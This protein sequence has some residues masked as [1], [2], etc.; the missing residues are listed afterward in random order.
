M[1]GRRIR[2]IALLITI[3]LVGGLAWSIHATIH[4]DELN[5][6]LIIAVK[7][8][9]AKTV[10]TLLGQG[11][12]PNSRDETPRQ[13]SLWYLLNK[14]WRRGTT[15]SFH[16]ALLIAMDCDDGSKVKLRE[17][18]VIIKAL[19]DSGADISAKDEDGSTPLIKACMVD[20]LDSVKLL[21]ARG[22]NVN[23]RDNSGS[24][25]LI[26]SAHFEPAVAESLL[27]KGA[28][29]DSQDM[30]GWTALMVASHATRVRTVELLLR[31]HPNLD[32]KQNS[33]DTALTL[34]IYPHTHLTKRIVQI[35][36]NAGARE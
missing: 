27:E 5:H 8:N 13:I 29:V 32:L 16:S 24:T 20:K 34:A 28:S 22:A 4:Q 3:S 23:A 35:L 18:L 31:Y 17:N 15:L 1:R 21:L 11:A 30:Y 19:L 14:Y 6:S 26:Y 33:N 36:K 25:P 10:L 7:H 9:D 12:N 2:L